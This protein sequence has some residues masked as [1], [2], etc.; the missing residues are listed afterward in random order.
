MDNESGIY[1]SGVSDIG[2]KSD[3][4]EVYE[5]L[6]KGSERVRF[7]VILMDKG[8]DSENVHKYVNEE[9]KARSIIP[10][11]N[12]KEH[13]RGKYRKE[14]TEKFPKKLYNKRWLIEAEIGRTKRR[15]GC[16]L[17]SKKIENQ[18]IEG[19]FWMITHN[20]AILLCL[21][22]YVFNTARFSCP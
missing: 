9:L 1:I 6:E 5:I 12:K 19:M 8:Y 21:L 20:L 2:P 7:D 11:I 3:I 17:W 15:I 4:C 22:F 14:L 16:M 10:V 18:L 13:K